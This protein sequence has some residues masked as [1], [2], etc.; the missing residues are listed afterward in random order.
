MGHDILIKVDD[1]T[2]AKLYDTLLKYIGANSPKVHSKESDKKNGI[3][4][5]LSKAEGKISKGKIKKFARSRLYFFHHTIV[6]DIEPS[7]IIYRALLKSLASLGDKTTSIRKL[8]IAY[9][10]CIKKEHEDYSHRL[11]I[12]EDIYRELKNNVLTYPNANILYNKL[13]E[14]DDLL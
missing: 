3:R 12:L 6:M 10:E 9:F 8:L 5:V 14:A 1:R 7:S 13:E 2:E 4:V 11:A